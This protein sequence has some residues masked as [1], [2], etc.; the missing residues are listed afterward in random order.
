MHY[1]KIS[2]PNNYSQKFKTIVENHKKVHPKIKT[3]DK[4]NQEIH[5]KPITLNELES[6]IKQKQNSAPGED[7]LPYSIFKKLPKSVL[8]NVVNFFN[9]I[10]QSGD[11]PK[12][13]KH[14]IIV[15]I[16]KPEKDP[17]LPASYR[18]IALTD[19]LGKLLETIVNNRLTHFLESKGIISKNQ[20]GFRGKRQ[21]MDQLSRLVAEVEKCRKLNRQTAAVFLDLE[22]AYDLLW[23]EGT[24]TEL[25]EIGVTGQIYNYILSFLQDRTFQVRVGG[26][27]SM[28]YEQET[29]TPQGAVLSPTIFNILINKAMKVLEKYKAIAAGQYADDSALWL[30]ALS[31][32]RRLYNRKKKHY[33]N[34]AI[35]RTKQLIKL[36]TEE[37]IN[38]LEKYGF[39]VNVEKT[40]IMFFDCDSLPEID[41]NGNKLTASNVVK[42][43][44]V[45]LDKKLTFKNHI[46]M[47]SNRGLKSLRI[48]S[49]LC[50]RKWGLKSR[51][52]LY[53]YLN[54]ILPKF[55]YGEE[56]FDSASKT[57]LQKLDVI[58]NQALRIISRTIR[59][60]KTELLPILTKVDPLYIRRKKKKLNLF[61]RFTQNTENPT[62]DIFHKIN[63]Q[64]KSVNRL[65]KRESMV[66]DI[67]N[68]QHICK[69]NR[70]MIAELPKPIPLWV[71]NPLNIDTC[72]STKIDKK[73]SSPSFMK[74]TAVEYLSQNYT[75]HS[76]I[77]TDASKEDSSVGIGIFFET[78]EKSYAYKLN[79]HLAITT[80][81]LVAIKEVFEIIKNEQNRLPQL[82]CICTDSLGACQALQGNIK[83]ISRP[84][85]VNTIRLLQNEL[86]NKLFRIDIVWIPSH[87]SIDG[88]E[89]ADFL[90]NK[91]RRKISV[92]K[93]VK[94]GYFELKS[95]ITESINKEIYSK[96]YSENKHHQVVDFKK[97]VPNINTKINLDKDNYM[98]NR[99][100]VG[101]VQFDLPNRETYCLKCKCQ[102]TIKH[103]IMECQLFEN[104]RC[105]IILELSKENIRF[106]MTSF[107]SLNNN[108]L[109][110]KAI[111][112]MIKAIDCTFGI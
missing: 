48:L 4:N 77:Y 58:Q 68:L 14:A 106:N 39:K 5:N 76:K 2:S 66:D 83:N 91:G 54:Y 41:I 101:A 99:L 17:K 104:E 59:T 6:V 82:L 72:I 92:D 12:A 103:V 84:D 23:R 36:A 55:S 26:S 110:E 20:S 112:K 63:I 56:L 96:N 65:G 90:A 108:R 51:H 25:K 37:L 10:W 85:I 35:Q 87:V 73:S 31:A 38:S 3:K 7:N 19:H 53:L 71:M 40:H 109:C 61:V 32:P 30:K 27:L 78:Q 52:R 98:I 9:D 86:A 94:L 18:P 70:K 79:D 47:L 93:N 46:K 100:R 28:K 105:K 88:N 29:G 64:D 34:L 57:H 95:L 102:L 43:L 97:I 81:E 45:L 69:I 21:C 44:G 89:M 1:S 11:I 50:G 8:Q 62:R 13:F 80:A 33:R 24:L 15:P 111:M 49:Y 22:K 107:L 60:T 16:L 67:I 74:K 75:N 42:Y